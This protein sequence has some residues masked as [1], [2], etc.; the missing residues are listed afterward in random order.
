MLLCISVGAA[1]WQSTPIHGGTT[2]RDKEYKKESCLGTTILQSCGRTKGYALH[3]WSSGLETDLS[4]QSLQRWV[5]SRK[6][7]GLIK[8]GT[9]S[10][11][12]NGQ[13]RNKK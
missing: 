8:G 10:Q 7:A 1:S 6:L 12:N 3:I 5:S 4:V 13:K 9:E 11:K 2:Y